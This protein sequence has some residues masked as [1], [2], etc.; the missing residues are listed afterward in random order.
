MWQRTPTEGCLRSLL[1]QP[2]RSCDGCGVLSREPVLE[3]QLLHSWQPWSQLCGTQQSPPSHPTTATPRRST[4]IASANT[5]LG[6]AS[7]LQ[8][9][10]PTE[11]QGSGGHGNATWC[12]RPLGLIINGAQ[13]S[14]SPP[15][16][17]RG[18]FTGK[19]TGHAQ[20]H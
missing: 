15:D 16:L 9:G 17:Y 6:Q 18:C 13:R 12:L 10:R 11:D 8:T 7:S 5:E 19:R 2:P 4:A 3:K 14:V 1:N 20:P